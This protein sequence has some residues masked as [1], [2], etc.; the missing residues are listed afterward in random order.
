M[1]ITCAAFVFVACIVSL[2][3]LRACSSDG[4]SMLIQSQLIT[5]GHGSDIV[6]PMT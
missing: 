3:F 6:D 2:A 1:A 5:N 4:A